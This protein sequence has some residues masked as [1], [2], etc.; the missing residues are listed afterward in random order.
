MY[1]MTKNKKLLRNTNLQVVGKLR[2][3]IPIH[4]EFRG[5]RLQGLRSCAEGAVRQK[6]A[7]DRR[8]AARGLGHM[9]LSRR[10]T[11]SHTK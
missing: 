2:S 7:V 10:D 11:A 4:R 5:I 8:T 9:F 6:V 1:L 3:E